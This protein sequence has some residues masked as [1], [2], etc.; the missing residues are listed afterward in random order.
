MHCSAAATQVTWLCL[1]QLSWLW[2]CTSPPLRERRS[3]VGEQRIHTITPTTIAR[4]LTTRP[5]AARTAQ[6]KMPCVTARSAFSVRSDALSS[7]A[8]A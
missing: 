3:A 6:T 7:P 5:A 1:R 8:I 4:T 2:L